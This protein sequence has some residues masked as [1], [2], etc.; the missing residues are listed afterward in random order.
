MLEHPKHL[1]EEE[2]ALKLKKN[3]SVVKYN[4]L[5]KFST[6]P[7]EKSKDLYNN[8]YDETLNK[9]IG[10]Y[11]KRSKL[12]YFSWLDFEYLK[13]SIAD[14]QKLVEDY[15]SR[16]YKNLLVVGMGGSGINAL[17]LRNALFENNLKPEKPWIG[18]QNNLDTSSMLSKLK[19]LD[20]LSILN[21]T[22]LLFI[23]KSGG[24]DEVRRNINSTI[25]YLSDKYGN[26]E[27]ALEIFAK[28]SIFITE[29]NEGN[30]LNK[31]A[32]EI[33]EKTDVEIPVLE[34]HPE[35]GGRF[36]MFSSVGML[37]ALFMDLDVNKLLIGAEESFK[38]LISKKELESSDLAQLALYDIL[39]S[40]NNYTNKY[41][42]V[43]S[44]SLEALNKFRAQLKGESLNKK[45]IDSTIHIPGVG[46]VNHH[47]DLELLFKEN[48]GVILEQIVFVEPFTDHINQDTGL[49]CLDDIK[50]QSNH[51]ALL[52]SHVIPIYKYLAANNH[53]VFISFIDKQNEESLG[54][55]LM[56]D[57]LITVLQAGLQGKLD[58]AIRQW[59]VERYKKDVKSMNLSKSSR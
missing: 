32:K 34:H 54:Y 20:E 31:L 12:E 47:S 57:M 17:V 22:V 40:Q 29:N 42:M 5:L 50:E 1:I 10:Q 9:L 25:D 49:D 41:S 30:F 55:F 33:K 7:N 16:S 38:D 3:K 28:Q 36:S 11:E 56:Q 14:L 51:L 52:K 26:N 46:T 58:D 8:L 43:Y 23:S 37:P 13:D 18:V 53:P 39:L 45:G 21:Q 35:I 4:E 6:P 15:R 44:D 19:E 2:F 27:T 59:E 24:T 48:N